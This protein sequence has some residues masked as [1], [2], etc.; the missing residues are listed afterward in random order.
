MT[1]RTCKLQRL[2]PQ[3]FACLDVIGEFQDILVLAYIRD[4]LLAAAATTTTTATQIL[5]KIMRL[6]NSSELTPIST[7]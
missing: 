1:T 5:S 7:T 6:V 2:T 3:S 4:L